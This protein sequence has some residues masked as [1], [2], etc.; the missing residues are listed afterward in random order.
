MLLF[1]YQSE[2]VSPSLVGQWNLVPCL[3]GSPVKFLEAL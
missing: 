3:S 2:N 1:S